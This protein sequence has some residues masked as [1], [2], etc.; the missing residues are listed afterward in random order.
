MSQ[1]HVCF[2]YE[3]SQS[4]N[5]S[6]SLISASTTCLLKSSELRE[7]CSANNHRKSSKNSSKCYSI[8]GGNGWVQTM[9]KTQTTWIFKGNSQDNPHNGTGSTVDWSPFSSQGGLFNQASVFSIKLFTIHPIMLPSPTWAIKKGQRSQWRIIQIEFLCMN[10]YYL[11]L[12]SKSWHFNGRKG[13][14]TWFMCKS[15]HC[16]LK[17]LRKLHHQL[18]LWAWLGFKVLC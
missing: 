7:H 2:I 12:D 17:P 5:E 3:K 8:H 10:S 15:Q 13:F 11:P 4:A 18:W 9:Q 6:R 14:Y 16:N 1:E